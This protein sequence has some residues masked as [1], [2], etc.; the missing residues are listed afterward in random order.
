MTDFELYDVTATCLTCGAEF[1]G[2]AFV[3]SATTGTC[4]TCIAKAEARMDTLTKHHPRHPTRPIPERRNDDRR[5][6]FR[7][8]AA[9]DD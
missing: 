4:P 8:R 9:G 3:R 2:K 6:D 7:R 5:V 1:Q